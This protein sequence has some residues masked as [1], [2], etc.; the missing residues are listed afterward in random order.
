[1]FIIY[2]LLC[3]IVAIVYVVKKKYFILAF[4]CL[5]FLQPIFQKITDPTIYG[6]T[7]RDI[8]FQR[9]STSLML[10]PFFLL[11][12]PKFRPQPRNEVV[13]NSFYF[14]L[15][16]LFHLISTFFSEDV[17]QSF[18]LLIVA[19]VLPV[20]FYYITM[21][22]ETKY[23]ELSAI[24]DTIA[25]FFIFCI[26]I[27]LLFIIFT[28]GIDMTIFL[29]LRT[30]NGLWINNYSGQIF[31]LFIPILLVKN[32]Q[33]R[34]LLKWGVILGLSVLFVIA[35]SRT[36]IAIFIFQLLILT[37]TK[38]VSKYYLLSFIA[39]FFIL[40]LILVSQYEIDV[41]GL[42]L[43]RFLE[44]NN[45]IMET[46]LND[47]RFYIYDVSWELIKKNW[48]WGIGLGNFY[49]YTVDGFSDSHNIF[50]SLLVG[51]GLL[52][53]CLI[54]YGFIYF[55][56]SNIKTWRIA[57]QAE[58]KILLSLLVGFCGYLLASLTGSEL[59]IYSGLCNAWPMYFLILAFI[60]QIKIKDSIIQ[61]K[62]I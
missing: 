2:I 58:K 34:R 15:L 22:I 11:L 33:N 19:I 37:I 46:T 61:R 5:L 26:F 55:I 17:C 44:G 16:F 25:C 24:T 56:K 62:Q 35:L 60:I 40:N 28:V 31:L 13:K 57:E 50:L 52:N 41:V 54:I 12:L 47:P 30:L 43:S 59:Y 51:R 10:V 21:S 7:L 49:K 23:F 48:M 27:G 53:F 14:F 39:S 32:Y 38:S 18:N 8:S 42:L 29:E 20:I 1:M 6:D 3:C 4:F 36:I 9:I 45:T